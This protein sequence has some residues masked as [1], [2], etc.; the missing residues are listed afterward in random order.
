MTGVEASATL[1][2]EGNACVD[3][4][5]KNIQPYIQSWK[6]GSANACQGWCSAVGPL[7]TLTLSSAGGDGAAC[8]QSSFSNGSYVSG[9]FIPGEVKAVVAA[10]QR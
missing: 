1:T 4:C 5:N 9:G 8:P 7:G 10:C 3:F 2:L 6:S